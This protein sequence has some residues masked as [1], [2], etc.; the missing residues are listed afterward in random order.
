MIENRCGISARMAAKVRS[1]TK[2]HAMDVASSAVDS[3]KRP[4]EAASHSLDGGN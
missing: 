3:T 4:M 2:S 1:L